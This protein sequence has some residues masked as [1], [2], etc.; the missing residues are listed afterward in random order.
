MAVQR[1]AGNV[2]HE[3]TASVAAPVTGLT[4][5]FLYGQAVQPD[6]RSIEPNLED[7]GKNLQETTDPPDTDGS[8]NDD[9]E[10][11]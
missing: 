8:D 9:E 4:V 7:V 10:S 5:A 3:H 1:D 2:I 11:L 6:A